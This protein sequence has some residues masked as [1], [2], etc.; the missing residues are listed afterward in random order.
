MNKL[1]STPD[2]S[3]S[4]TRTFCKMNE[5]CAEDLSKAINKHYD[6]YRLDTESVLGDVLKVHSPERIAYVLAVRVHDNNGFDGRFSKAN[7]DWGKSVLANVADEFKN[8]NTSPIRHSLNY[9]SVHNG[10]ADMV[11]TK[12]RKEFPDIELEPHTKPLTASVKPMKDGALTNLSKPSFD[13]DYDDFKDMGYLCIQMEYPDTQT[14][15]SL[16]KRTDLDADYISDTLLG[17]NESKNC[18]ADVY[19][20]GSILLIVSGNS[21]NLEPDEENTL[22]NNL[23]KYTKERFGLSLA[24][25]LNKAMRGEKPPVEAKQ[26]LI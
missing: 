6:G 1:F 16:M 3:D 17:K 12:F 5:R 25:T 26:I 2:L 15:W 23:E 22:R 19:E 24:K 9:L 10:L 7:E 8:K 21:V 13:T 18:Y 14:A 11:M 4:E 20:D